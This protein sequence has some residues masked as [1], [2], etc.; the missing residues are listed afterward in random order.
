MSRL[1]RPG[2]LL[3]LVLFGLALA[4]PSASATFHEVSVREVYPGSGAAPDSEYVELQMWAPGQNLVGGH[5]VVVYNGT[6]GV[7]GSATFAGNVSGSANQSTI[8]AATAA[9]TGEFG[10]GADVG[11]APGLLDP[12]A[13]AVCWESLDCVSWGSFSGSLPS[14]AGSP[15]TPSGIPDG[16]ALRRTIEPGCPTLLQA[17]D[18]S[19][20]SATDFSTVFPMPRPN[21]VAPEEHPCASTGNTSGGGAGGQD[22]RSAPQTKLRRKPPHRTRDRTP[23]FRFTSGE[24]H[25]TFQ[26]KLDRKRFRRCRSPFTAKRLTVGRH[27]FMV[28]A[29]DSSG[30]LDPSPASYRFRVIGRPRGR[31]HSLS[32]R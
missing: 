29:R 30:T 32:G 1:H 17:S 27:T 10:V 11:L 3:S 5:S 19:N 2:Y 31:R 24:P 20:D 22:G 28:R 9:A 4:A 18:D 6:G 13:G 12:T 21:S 14:P 15:A 25:S 7:A 16:M 23:T 8:L 26:C